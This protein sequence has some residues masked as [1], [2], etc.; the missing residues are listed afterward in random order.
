MILHRENGEKRARKTERV[1][2]PGFSVRLAALSAA[3]GVAVALAA[4]GGGVAKPAGAIRR[5]L[6]TAKSPSPAAD[7]QAPS[8]YAHYTLRLKADTGDEQSI[9]VIAP[10][11]GLKITKRDMTGDHVPNDVVITPALLHWPLTVLVNDGSH[12]E[13][14]ISAANPGSVSGPHQLSGGNGIWDISALSPSIFEPHTVSN[15]GGVLTPP[16]RERL[17]YSIEHLVF[18]LHAIA[19]GPGR[20]P[21]ASFTSI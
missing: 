12:F 13:V 14:A 3:A 2:W 4:F 15:R 17:L 9:V 21:P 11:G 20:G 1:S 18:P 19:S 10:P 5:Q 8:W 16:M 6:A 7:S